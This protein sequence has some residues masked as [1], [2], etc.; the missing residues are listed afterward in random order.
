MD[1]FLDSIKEILIKIYLQILF[2]VGAFKGRSWVD[3]H[4]KVCYNKLDE[5]NSDYDK[6]TR[7]DWYPKK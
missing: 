1:S 5:I 2:F 4:I 6:A 3:K 7:R